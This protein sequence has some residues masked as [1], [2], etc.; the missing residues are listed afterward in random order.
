MPQYAGVWPAALTQRGAIKVTART[1]SPIALT[2]TSVPSRAVV[3]SASISA[4]AV[5]VASRGV[6]AACRDT[7]SGAIMAA[8]T[9]RPTKNSARCAD[10][11]I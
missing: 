10:G 11:E 7:R 3:Q 6:T 2:G 9:S 8:V 5:A 1:G 4:V